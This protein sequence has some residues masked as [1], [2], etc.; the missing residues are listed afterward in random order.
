MNIAE[1][2]TEISEINNYMK[3][4]NIMSKRLWKRRKSENGK[5]SFQ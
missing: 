4:E 5:N 2:S 1:I 3:P